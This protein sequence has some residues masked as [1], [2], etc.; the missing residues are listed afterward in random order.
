MKAISDFVRS[1][2]GDRAAGLSEARRAA[3]VTSLSEITGLV[4][5]VVTLVYVVQALIKA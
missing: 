3:V 1:A 4:F 2:I 5:C